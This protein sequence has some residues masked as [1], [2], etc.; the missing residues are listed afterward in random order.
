[1]SG[2]F[3]AVASATFSATARHCNGCQPSA[4]RGDRAVHHHE[5]EG[6]QPLDAEGLDGHPVGVDE[7]EEL[8]GQRAEEGRG[9]L[10]VGGHQPADA[11]VGA[12]ERAEHSGGG[13]EDPRALVGVR[14]DH[15]RGEVER[16]QPL[17]DGAAI[18]VERREGEVGRQFTRHGSGKVAPPG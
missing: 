3:Q 1:M 13:V 14:I 18:A 4:D 15:H 17:A 5:R 10:G 6:R 9:A 12:P 7:G 11:H 16:G 2:A 8:V